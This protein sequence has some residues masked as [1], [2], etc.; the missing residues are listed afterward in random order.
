MALTD[1]SSGATWR[2]QPSHIS[3]TFATAK[4]PRLSTLSNVAYYGQKDVIAYDGT[5]PHSACAA[6]HLGSQVLCEMEGS[7]RR[8]LPHAPGQPFGPNIGAHGPS[9]G[10]FTHGHGY[11][12]YTRPSPSTPIVGQ[13]I[14]PSA[15]VVGLETDHYF[16]AQNTSIGVPWQTK[17]KTRV[18]DVNAS[19]CVGLPRIPNF[20]ASDY[21]NTS[22]SN[23][24]TIQY[25]SHFESED[26][27]VPVGRG[28]HSIESNRKF[29]S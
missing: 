24:N 5:G 27:L 29:S 22:G 9:S 15:N 1:V 11:G 25:G 6:H 28:E 26:L 7:F 2:G 20:N 8:E 18:H 16:S 12:P 19:P 23:V 13:H 14:E 21:L 17:P 4:M 10:P 3:H